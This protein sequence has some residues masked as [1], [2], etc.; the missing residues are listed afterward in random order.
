MAYVSSG[1]ACTERNSQ[2][3]MSPAAI[4][5]QNARV[6]R[7]GNRFVKGNVTLNTLVQTL[8][9]VGIGE[10]VPGVTELAA[11]ADFRNSP[12]CDTSI[13]GDGSL[14]GGRIANGSQGPGLDEGGAFLPLSMGGNI[15]GSPASPGAPAAWTPGT[16]AGA[17]AA[18]AASSGSPG[19]TSSSSGPA[20]GPG[21]PGGIPWS[22]NAR[23]I[24]AARRCPPQLLPMMSVFPIPIPPPG[25]VSGPTPPA[26]TVPP[27]SA[28]APVASGGPPPGG[29][30]TTGNVC[31]DLALGYVIQNQVDPRQGLTCAEAGYMGNKDGPLLTE[32]FI[33]WRAANFNRLAK[34]PY[35]ANPPQAT[36]AML[37]QNGLAGYDGGGQGS[38]ICL[39]VIALATAAGVW[40]AYEESKGRS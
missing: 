26:G 1:A 12:G 31:L 27:A 14:Y 5:A 10:N 25:V 16:D 28:P 8:G 13:L 21:G 23:G 40:W 6:A 4:A 29:Y 37:V 34:V 30:P 35:V 17:S 20:V 39:V 9:G 3:P 33:Q 7:M 2:T 15:T 38:C 32:S 36:S 24:R 22:W 11:A 18:A 19:V